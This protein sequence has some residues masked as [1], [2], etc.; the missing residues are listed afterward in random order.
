MAEQTRREQI[1]QILSEARFTAFDLAERFQVKEK[2][3]LD[4]LKHLKR[5]LRHRDKDLII[6]PAECMECGFRFKTDKIK[7]PSRCPMCK[8]ERIEEQIYEVK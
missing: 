5:S 3:I 2:L 4:D 7:N 6:H 1:L 8:S